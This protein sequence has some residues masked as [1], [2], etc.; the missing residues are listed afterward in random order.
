[1][2]LYLVNLLLLTICLSAAAQQTNS[3]NYIIT[4]TY[5]QSGAD[6]NNVGL[7]NTQV[8]YFD[9]LGRPQQTVAVGQS[10]AGTDIVQHVSYDAYGRQDMQYLPYTTAGNGAYQPTAPAAA[11]GYYSSNS[12]GLQQIS[13]SDLTRPYRQTF[14]EQSPLSRPVGSQEPGGRSNAS[15]RQYKVNVASEVKRYDY[16]PAT[17]TIVSNGHYNA[18]TL[19]HLLTTDEEGNQSSEFRDVAL[20]QLI[21]RKVNTGTESLDTYYVYDDLGLLRAVLQPEYQTTPSN[22]FAFLYDYDNRARMIRKHIPG[23]GATETVYDNFD[24]AALTRDAGQAARGVWAFTKYDALNRPVVTGEIASTA[25]HTSWTATVAAITAHHENRSNGTTAGYSLNQ[26]APVTAT[27]AQLLTITFYDDYGFQKPAHLAYSAQ[28]GYPASYHTAVKG[29]VT[30]GRTRMLNTAASWLTHVVYYDA[31]YRPVQAVRQLYDL[32]T[33][34]IERVSTQY[35]YD[36]A[37]VVAQ[38]LTQQV[39]SPIL[40]NSLVSVFDYDH[41]DRLLNVRQTVTTPTQSKTAYTTAQR[42]NALGNLKEKGF[43]GYSHNPHD[44]RRRTDYTYNIRGWLTDSKTRYGIYYGDPDQPFYAIGLGYAHPSQAGKYSAGNI[45]SMEWLKKDETAFTSGMNFTYDGAGRLKAGSG[46]YGYADIENNITYDKNG[47]LKTLNSAGSAVDHLTYSYTGNRLSSLTDA[48]GNHSG[49]KG[50]T[51][52]YG[53]DANG[54]MITDGNRGATLTYNYLNLPQTVTAGSKT[55]SYD[56]DAAGSKHQYA[57]DTVNIKYAGAFEYGQGNVLKRI[58]F[59]EG[60]VIPAG[61]TLRFEYYLKDHLGNVKLVFDENGDILQETDYY[62]FGLAIAR[63]NPV[64]NDNKRNTTNRYL[65]NEKE[66]QVGSGYLDYGAR[67][68]MPEVGRWGVVD[69]LSEVSRRWSPYS[70]GYNNPLR[71][72][73]P[74]GRQALD[75]RPNAKALVAI[76]NGLNASDAKNV[77]LDSRGMIDREMI[78]SVN[79]ESGNFNALKQLVNDN[80]VYDIQVT[81]ELVYKDNDG[82]IKSQ[83]L[84]VSYTDFITGEKLL[85]VEGAQGF[86]AIPGNTNTFNSPD[87]EVKVVVSDGLNTLDQSKNIAH[88]AYGHAFMYSKGEDSAHRPVGK[89]ETNTNLGNQIKNRINETEKNFKKEN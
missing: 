72:I 68:Y 62:P 43:H 25:N 15:Q 29:Q 3:R 77:R 9:G 36:L 33:E 4:Q 76:Q 88:E 34:A 5:K 38:Q 27:E 17:N 53:Y 42:Y 45:S 83:K 21:C 60:Q 70:Y 80:Q 16:D 74:D 61:D 64:Q 86:T 71:F 73:D 75:V 14:F 7:V 32:G 20:D 51:S 50:G 28:M 56:Y 55:Y 67:M 8:Q 11:A 19:Q 13:P 85:E 84:E 82:N 48:S 12:L 66:L 24:R 22:D 47:N 63:D 26:T 41:A 23:A 54:N 31:E 10:P 6:A 37:P 39:L 40:T 44:Y 30:G 81:S 65:Y 49:V 46:L 57:G 18:G 1:M 78:N 59:S 87:E 52:S 2:K 79:S 69:P 35:K 89:K 58:G